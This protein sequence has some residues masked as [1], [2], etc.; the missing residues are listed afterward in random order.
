MVQGLREM[1]DC[2]HGWHTARFAAVLALLLGIAGMLPATADSGT[3][4]AVLGIYIPPNNTNLQS[5]F[6]QQPPTA[7]AAYERN[8]TA[9]LVQEKSGIRYTIR[10]S[11]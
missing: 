9:E 11:L 3:A 2:C 4:V 8:T 5:D 6:L 1:L 7:A 10:V